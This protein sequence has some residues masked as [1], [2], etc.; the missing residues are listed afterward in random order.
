MKRL[1]ILTLVTVV[2]SALASLAGDFNNP[3]M[4]PT[5]QSRLAALEG[6]TNSWTETATGFA[7][8]VAETHIVTNSAGA[9]LT[10][11]ITNATASTHD[12]AIDLLLTPSAATDMIARLGSGGSDLNYAISTFSMSGMAAATPETVPL[13]RTVDPSGWIDTTNDVFWIPAGVYFVY[14]TGR[15]E[16]IL[17][18][19]YLLPNAT[20]QG[21]VSKYGLSSPR[22]RWTTG[23]DYDWFGFGFAVKATNTTGV[24]AF[25]LTLQSGTAGT[26]ISG[27]AITVHKIGDLE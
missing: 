14:V 22:L 19:G 26:D 5:E 3:G 18:G 2:L 23:N 9:T 4:T 13:S 7:A 24:G 25:G 11:A 20:T 12:E 1:G 8:H 16:D 21:G 10:L 17:N 27:G 15:G 6:G